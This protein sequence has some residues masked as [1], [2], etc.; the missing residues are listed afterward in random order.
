MNRNSILWGVTILM[1]FK[2]LL[3]VFTISLLDVTIKDMA[4]KQAEY[5]LK[6][7]KDCSNNYLSDK[8]NTVSNIQD[9]L[10]QCASESLVAWPTWDVFAINLKDGSL[11]WDNSSDCKT[12]KVWYL[13]EWSICDLAKDSKS[14]VELW[15]QINKWVEWYIEWQFDNDKE[16]TKWIVIPSEIKWYNWNIRATSLK[17]DIFQVAIAQ[18]IQKD[19]LE[20]QYS[21]FRTV[22]IF[23]IWFWDITLLFLILFTKRILRTYGK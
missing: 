18:W 22:L 20:S 17:K 8:E 6:Q 1:V 15:K 19:E 23:L 9:S 5:N 13:K 21:F 7:I 3:W 12:N 16:Y 11:I 14:C 10:N 4:V 2:V